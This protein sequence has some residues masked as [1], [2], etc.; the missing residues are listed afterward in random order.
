[1]EKC[2]VIFTPL[3]L[4]SQSPL[5]MRLIGPRIG[6]ISWT[7][8]KHVAYARKTENHRNAVRITTLTKTFF[9]STFCER[10]YIMQ[11][12]QIF[13]FCLITKILSRIHCA[14]SRRGLGID[15]QWCRWG[16]FPKLPMEPCALVSSH[17]LKMSTRKTPGGKDG[18]C[19]R[20]T[21]YYLHSAESRED[22]GALTFGFA[23]AG[24][25]L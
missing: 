10:M 4:Y 9:F 2:D 7:E 19:V 23:R 20:V 8:D 18:R 24:L 16:F 12:R 6:P 21:T 17:P 14:T 1:M 22:P 3:T 25:G 15:P 5:D 11:I 13:V